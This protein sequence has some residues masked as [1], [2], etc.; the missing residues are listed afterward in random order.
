MQIRSRKTRGRVVA[1]LAAFSLLG[2]GYSSAA[3]AGM[4]ASSAPPAEAA[5]RDAEFHF[6]HSF[7]VN[8]FDPHRSP[9]PPGDSSWMRP[10]Y[11]RLLTLG[12]GSDGTVEVV[13]QLA[14]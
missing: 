5:D 13:P 1:A 8:S 9:S 2:A 14:T 4:D 7:G 6:G 12:Y 11:D 3:R 10:V